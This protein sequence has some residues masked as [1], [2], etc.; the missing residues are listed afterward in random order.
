MH[1]RSTY[2]QDRFSAS[3]TRKRP[4]YAAFHSNAPGRSLIF[5][6][7]SGYNKVL[8]IL[9]LYDVTNYVIQQTEYDGRGSHQDFL[10]FLME[11]GHMAQVNVMQG[12]AMRLFRQTREKIIASTIWEEMVHIIPGVKR[13]FAAQSCRK[14]GWPG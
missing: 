14:T 12:A 5:P 4:G 8:R 11:S 7:K 2:C 9:A 13:A 3:K 10:L 1:N 6:S